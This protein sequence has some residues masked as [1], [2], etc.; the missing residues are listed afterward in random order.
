MN[1]NAKCK[2]CD[3]SAKLIKKSH[4]IPNFMYKNMF[5]DNNRIL[6]ANLKNT[7]KP[8]QYR[9]SGLHEKYILCSK[10]EESLSKLERYTAHFLFGNNTKTPALFEKRLS[11][12]GIK[13]IMIKKIDYSKLKLCL[14]SIVWRAHISSDKFFKEI[15][16]GENEN[17]IKKMLLE[18]DCRE[19]EVFKISI[20]GIQGIDNAPLRLSLNPTVK[21]MGDGYLAMFFINGF[22]YF[23]NLEPKSDFKIFDKIFLKK[24][25]ELE[26]PLLEGRMA[27]EFLK[28]FGVPAKI[29]DNFHLI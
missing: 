6:L 25:G 5:D 17:V 24:I 10:C 13:S 28:S 11:S 26:V 12:D 15:N 16:I 1:Q 22:F 4:I 20:I 23:I 2:L 18:N 29:A 19:E 27:K 7:S 8:P 9:Q 21:K 3:K 14:L